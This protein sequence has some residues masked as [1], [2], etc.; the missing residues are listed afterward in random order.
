MEGGHWIDA[1]VRFRSTI[2]STLPP[3]AEGSVAEIEISI[4][5]QRL[6]N[7]SALS[8]LR[9]QTQCAIHYRV[10]LIP[11]HLGAW[12]QE[13]SHKHNNQLILAIHPKRGARGATPAVLSTNDGYAIL[14]GIQRHGA[15]ESEPQTL[16]SAT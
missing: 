14:W 10:K 9:S 13:L 11:Q 8:I 3:G 6:E 1:G 15:A 4:L 16:N 12:W 2:S 5:H 7:N